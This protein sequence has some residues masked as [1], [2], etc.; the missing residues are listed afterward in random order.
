MTADR[1]LHMGVQWALELRIH[2]V[3]NSTPAAMLGLS[4]DAIEEK[5]G[6]ALAGFWS[7]TAQAAQLRV[8]S[9]RV[10]PVVRQEAYSWGNLARNSIAGPT[11][12]RLVAIAARVGWVLLLPFGLVNVGYWTRKFDD[13][14]VPRKHHGWWHARGAASVRL[15]GVGLTLLLVVTTAVVALDLIGV[16]CFPANGDAAQCANQ[17]LKIRD[18]LGH[19]RQPQRLAVL[20]VLPVAVVAGLV[21]LSSATRL[22]YEQPDA[23]GLEAS[24]QSPRWPLLTTPGFW[25]HRQITKVSARLHLSASAVLVAVMTAVHV[26]FGSL[27]ACSSGAVF[28]HWNGACSAALRHPGSQVGW[29]FLVAGCGGGALVLVGFAL[30][31]HSADAG[32]VHL[33]TRPHRWWAVSAYAVSDAVFAGQTVLLITSRLRPTDTRLVGVDVVLTAILI[34]MLIV[35]VSAFLWR[36]WTHSGLLRFLPV[37]L[38]S[39]AV[40]GGV[41]A[42]LLGGAARAAAAVGALAAVVGMVAIKG[43]RPGNAF[44]AWR[45]SAPGVFMVMALLLAMVLSSAFVVAAGDW[46]NGFPGPSDLAH[47]VI[48]GSSGDDRVGTAAGG[49]RPPP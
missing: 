16:Q 29:E 48:E 19:L 1:G 36:D 26:A 14:P 9:G 45:G 47:H 28:V 37:V 8:Q 18:T 31:I 7:P 2:G 30:A 20:S 15:F 38:A 10:E 44:E 21:L 34:G 33:R 24:R 39:T 13:G 43:R 41:A 23:N 22:R 40:I 17:P 25:S 11:F 49:V 32:D 6:D 42:L 35:L 3:N 46:L 5:R 27:P 4:A 12:G